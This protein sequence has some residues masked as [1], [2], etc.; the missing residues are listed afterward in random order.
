MWFTGRLPPSERSPFSRGQASNSHKGRGKGGADP[1]E[2]LMKIYEEFQLVDLSHKERGKGVLSIQCAEKILRI[3]MYFSFL[4][5]LT[6]VHD[7]F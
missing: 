6:I 4:K 2:R 5:Q 1:Q 3:E 7:T